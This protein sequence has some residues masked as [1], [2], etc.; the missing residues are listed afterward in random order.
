[1]REGCDSGEIVGLR[2]G[3]LDGALEGCEIGCRDG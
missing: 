3:W 1:M 2:D